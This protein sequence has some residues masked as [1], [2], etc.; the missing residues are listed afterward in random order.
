MDKVTIG[1]NAGKIWQI[2]S[3]EGHYKA[4]TSEA[5]MKESGLSAPDFYVAIGWLAREDKLLLETSGEK[6]HITL[7]LNIYI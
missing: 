4:W 6:T 3:K 7:S 2:L 1:F 5:L